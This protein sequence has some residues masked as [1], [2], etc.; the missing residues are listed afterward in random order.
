MSLSKFPLV[1]ALPGE[2]RDILHAACKMSPALGDTHLKSRPSPSP[3]RAQRSAR[4][5]VRG[6]AGPSA[7]RFRNARFA[8]APRCART[9]TGR[10]LPGQKGNAAFS[11]GDSI[12]AR[13]YYRKSLAKQEAF[14]TL[15]NSGRAEAQDKL[16]REAYEHLAYCVALY[17][18]DPELAD[19]REKF[20]AL[21]SE[22]R[23]RLASDV[24]D[25]IDGK[26]ATDMRERAERERALAEGPDSGL[27]TEPEPAAD[28]DSEPQMERVKW[29]LP[30]VLSLAGA[31]VAS[32]VFGGVM[33]GISGGQKREAEE[34]REG[35]SSE[36]CPT[37]TSSSECGELYD[38]LDKSDASFNMGIAGLVGAGAFVVSAV[39]VQ[40]LVPGQRE[41]ATRT[42]TLAG[43]DPRSKTFVIGVAGAF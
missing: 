43:F 7:A 14:D 4:A 3:S 33:L 17:P 36:D 41:V 12:L 27:E 42:R 5:R 20:V 2:S 19:A 29:K 9:G 35:R 1:S 6:E 25:E 39:A 30:L 26:V 28:V 32:G 24:L 15:C 31:G 34:L 38:A 8:H 37:E 22:V 16:F 21:K 11:N 18:T 10:G 13:D 40:L 23:L